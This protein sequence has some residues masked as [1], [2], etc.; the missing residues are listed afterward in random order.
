MYERHDS[1]KAKKSRRR[2]KDILES[3]AIFGEN[4]NS[5][6]N[7]FRRCLSYQ[8]FVAFWKCSKERNSGLEKPA[9]FDDSIYDGNFKVKRNDYLLEWKKDCRNEIDEETDSD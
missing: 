4:D 7:P 3:T 8:A 1:N 9:N 6:H 5:F 2:I